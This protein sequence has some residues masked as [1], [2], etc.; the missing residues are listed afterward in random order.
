[1]SVYTHIENFSS[2]IADPDSIRQYGPYTLHAL[3]K[4]TWYITLKSNPFHVNKQVQFGCL[5]IRNDFHSQLPF[6]HFLFLFHE[7]LG[8]W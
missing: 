6:D 7:K 3:G 4:V 1:M 2:N 5:F 8:F